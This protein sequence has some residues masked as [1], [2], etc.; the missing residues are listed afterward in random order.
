MNSNSNSSKA[1]HRD[2]PPALLTMALLRQHYLPFDERTIYRMI[3]AGRFPKAELSIGRKLRAW[4]RETVEQ[5]VEA[6]QRHSAPGR[7]LV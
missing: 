5:W 4:R 2:A 6:P 7:E 1:G 3:S